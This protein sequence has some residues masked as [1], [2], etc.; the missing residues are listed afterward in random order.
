[1]GVDDAIRVWD[2]SLEGT[3]SLA[4]AT[5]AAAAVKKLGDV[6]LVICGKESVDVGTDHHIY[7]TAR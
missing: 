2:A 7:Q 3:D 5:A 4:F 1:M 6:D